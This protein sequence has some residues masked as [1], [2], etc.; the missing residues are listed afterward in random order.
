[1]RTSIAHIASYYPSR[2][3]DLVEHVTIED[4]LAAFDARVDAAGME[5]DDEVVVMS[6][7]GLAN[8]AHCIRVSTWG[9]VLRVDAAQTSLAK[10]LEACGIAVDA[11]TSVPQDRVL[12]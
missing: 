1:M 12:H 8:L 11:M 2:P 5:P 9:S 4:L 7:R 10:A 3:A 6:R